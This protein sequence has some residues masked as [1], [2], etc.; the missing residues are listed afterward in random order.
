MLGLYKRVPGARRES[1]LFHGVHQREQEYWWERTDGES[2][3]FN[4]KIMKEM[5]GGT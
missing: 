3:D 1:R 5:R 2:S 4:S